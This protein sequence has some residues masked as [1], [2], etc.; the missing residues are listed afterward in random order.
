MRERAILELRSVSCSQSTLFSVRILVGGKAESS[1]NIGHG[2]L[3]MPEGTESG[4]SSSA[5]AQMQLNLGAPDRTR[6]DTG[7]ILSPLSLPL[8]YGG[9]RESEVYYAKS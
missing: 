2:N 3:S 4:R 5:R 9:Q 8:D 7:R 6:T 1:K